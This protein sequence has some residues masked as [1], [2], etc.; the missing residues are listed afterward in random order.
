M[1]FIRRKIANGICYYDVAESFREDGVVKK[2]ILI[3]LGRCPNIADAIRVTEIN[4]KRYL[5]NPRPARAR[6]RNKAEKLR[7]KLEIL[8]NVVTKSAFLQ[9]FNYDYIESAL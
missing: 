4:L 2:R 9:T 8:Q 5:A 7:R 3:S 1:A 6:D